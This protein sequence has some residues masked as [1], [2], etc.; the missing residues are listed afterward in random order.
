MRARSSSIPRRSLRSGLGL[1]WLGLGLCLVAGAPLACDTIQC[2]DNQCAGGLEWY[3]QLD[4][5]GAL[6]PGAYAFEAELDGTRVA[7]ECSIA[8][9]VG[10][11]DC[12]APVVLEGDA[13]FELEVG[14]RG[15]MQGFQQPSD[16]VGRIVFNANESVSGGVRGP[17]AVHIVGTRDGQPVVDDTYELTYER[18][19]SYHGDER[20]GFCDLKETRTSELDG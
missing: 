10:D 13:D 3:A 1:P 9:S 16:H 15:V 20:C 2:N 4:G 7:F 6:L 11:S 18:D 12:E 14:L 17:E 8:E 19:E 5:G